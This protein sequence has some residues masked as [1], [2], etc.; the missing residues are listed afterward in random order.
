MAND[1][2]IQAIRQAGLDLVEVADIAQADPRT[3][4]RWLGGRVPHPRYRKRLAEALHVEEQELWP[5]T[6]R[7]RRKAALREITAAAARS[8]DPDAPDWRALL[9]AA[10]RQVDLLGYSLHQVTEARQW[11]KLLA[12]AIGRGCQIRIAVAAPNSEV[13]AA[14]DAAQRPPGRLISRI[15]E[16]QVKLLALSRL[17]GIEVREHRVATTHTILRFDDQMLLTIHLHGTPGFQAP[18]L[19]LRR[20][21]DYGIFDQ[22]VAHFEDVWQT[23]LQLGAGGDAAAQP[24]ATASARRSAEEEKRRYL[25]SLDPVWKT[26]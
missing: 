20:E 13:V 22:L 25:E 14:A 2:L 24:A 16:S 5:E 21:S 18:V 17:P 15:R 7:V 23:A 19:Q 12:A 4:Q 11:D 1:L 3:V 9:R 10:E 8:G 26:Q 6:V